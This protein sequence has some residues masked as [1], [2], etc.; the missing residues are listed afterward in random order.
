M[1]I[2]RAREYQADASG[3]EIVGNPYGL[4]SAL[5]KLEGFSK[6]LP[7]QAT[8]NT[9]HMFI[10]QPFSGASLMNIFS[11]HPPVAKRIERLLGR[12]P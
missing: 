9:A 11:T 2:S 4:A 1:A 10:V 8:P 5:Q 6:R 7:F 12:C 3:A